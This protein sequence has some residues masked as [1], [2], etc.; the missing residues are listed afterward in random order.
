MA[1]NRHVSHRKEPVSAHGSHLVHVLQAHELF[2]LQ[3]HTFTPGAALRAV[4]AGLWA[5]SSLDAEQCTPL[6]L[7][8]IAPESNCL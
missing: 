6:H 3:A 4:C 1:I 8:H 5:P 2:S 7:R